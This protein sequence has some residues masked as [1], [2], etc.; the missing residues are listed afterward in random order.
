MNEDIIDEII[1]DE[2]EKNTTQVEVPLGYGRVIVCKPTLVK[3]SKQLIHKIAVALQKILLCDV[4]ELNVKEDEVFVIVTEPMKK[5]RKTQMEGLQNA[6]QGLIEKH[7]KTGG[8][9]EIQIY[10]D[11]YIYRKEGRVEV[12]ECIYKDTVS[13][14]KPLK[15]DFVDILTRDYEPTPKKTIVEFPYLIF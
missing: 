7:L 11:V 8:F 12:D 1:N 5:V 14:E 6:L 2:V 4:Q 3:N 9:V 13:H 10:R 15:G